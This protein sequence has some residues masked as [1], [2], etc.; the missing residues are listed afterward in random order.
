M[1]TNGSFIAKTERIDAYNSL[2][3]LKSYTKHNDSDDIEKYYD[4]HSGCGSTITCVS[5]HPSPRALL[6]NPTLPESQR[7]SPNVSV[8]QNRKILTSTKS[9]N[10]I[11]QCNEKVY[12]FI[13]KEY[14][15]K[16]AKQCALRPSYSTPK[17]AKLTCIELQRPLVSSHLSNKTQITLTSDN[18]VLD[19]TYNTDGP[20]NNKSHLLKKNAYIERI[21]NVPR[22]SAKI[23][24]Y[25]GYRTNMFSKNE[26][27]LTP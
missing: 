8:H 10:D 16:K 2:E 15:I 27:V 26:K 21:G 5:Q 24:R 17:L 1:E 12:E 11:N 14:S 20:L 7:Q 13:R 3:N 22:Y 19:S 18:N 25:L 4:E 23:R 9:V 6:H